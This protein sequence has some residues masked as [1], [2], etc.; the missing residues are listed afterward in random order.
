M[1]PTF[2]HG[3]P[4]IYS[5][6]PASIYHAA[7]G[8][9]QSMLN[10]MD[11][12]ARLPAYLKNGVDPTEAMLLGTFIH[13]RVLEPDAPLPGFAVQ[14]ETY[15]AAKGE[16]KPWHNGAKACKEWRIAQETEGKQ[17]VTREFL[18]T[19]LACTG[20]IRENCGDVFAQGKAELSLFCTLEGVLTKRR[21]DWVP[22]GLPYLVDVKKVRG[23][24]GG[25]DA[26][27][28][29][30]L[31][32]RYHVQAASYLLG[33]NALMSTTDMR[34]GFMFVVVEDEAPFLVSRYL[35]GQD[36]LRIGEAQYVQDLA[37]YKRCV[38]EEHFP[39]FSPAPV[40]LNAPEWLLR[41]AAR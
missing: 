12:P 32:R 40:E 14:P 41:K 27:L 11:P 2:E 34:V 38:L 15:T 25:P 31:A 6:L 17:V 4:G 5:D 37:T 29:T 9:S 7:P 16:V 3:V 1:T 18:E 33:W 13:S 39:G 20:A 26:F 30:M 19:V 28:K 35:V 22:E 8:V 23:G 10:H 21:I 24:E 36:L